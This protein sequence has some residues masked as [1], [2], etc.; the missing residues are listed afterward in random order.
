MQE[1]IYSVRLLLFLKKVKE[2]WCWAYVIES[3]RIII[4]SFTCLVRSKISFRSNINWIV[5]L[6]KTVCV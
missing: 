1:I 2:I 4:V 3:L 6:F 5:Y